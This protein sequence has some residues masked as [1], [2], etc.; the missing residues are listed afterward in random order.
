MTVHLVGAGPGDPG[1]LTVRGADLLRDADFVVHDRLVSPAILDLAERAERIDVGKAPSGK[2]I[3]QEKINQ[4]LIQLGRTG[5]QVVRLK[6]G[7]PFVFGRGGEEAIALR[8]A[9]VAYTIVPGISSA[10]GVPAIA[11]IPVTHRHFARSVAIVT[12]RED[13]EGPGGVNWE[14]LAGS[15][16]TIVV[17]MG[18]ARIGLIAK[19]LIAGGL[20][21]A[22]PLAAIT[23]SGWSDET[24]TRATLTDAVCLD[25]P[26]ATT[27]VI[28]T[29]AAA[30][31]RPDGISHLGGGPLASHID[32]NVV[33]K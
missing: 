18:A 26:P 22:T 16:D 12:G 23:R 3:Q 25:L 11:G 33:A 8:A 29:V 20:H 17:L 28:G 32:P 2:T 19:R 10:I 24:E 6:G 21:P 5:R 30:D 9:G 14:R 27:V 15:V 7:D 4:L 13:P 1:L 31:V